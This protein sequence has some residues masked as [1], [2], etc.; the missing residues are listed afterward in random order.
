MLSRLS[1]TTSIFDRLASTTLIAAA[2][3]LLV[4]GGAVGGA[5]F[6]GG[7]DSCEVPTTGLDAR[8]TMLVT[9]HMLACKDLEAG[10]IT[11]AQYNT[12]LAMLDGA[13]S[14]RGVVQ[15]A[16]AIFADTVLGF[17]TQYSDDSW[18]AKQ[19]LGMPNVFP[20]SG[21]M[22]KAWASHSADEQA[23]W[24][25]LGYAQ[26]VPVSAVEIYQTYNPGA[27]EAIQ[28]ITTSGR[29]IELRPTSQN[30]TD[31]KLV[32]E[33]PCTSESIAAVRVNLASQIVSGW[34]EIDAVGLVP[35]R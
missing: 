21:D 4:C 17:S 11:K 33:T 24:I 14:E 28:L 5:M 13:A 31:P 22:P 7:S 16:Q 2:A 27:V 6:G 29:R 34:N 26:P 18:A 20:A 1:S 19:A 3:G 25:E 10:R 15:P 23:E 32:V 35:C 9:R 30:T 8:D 12:T